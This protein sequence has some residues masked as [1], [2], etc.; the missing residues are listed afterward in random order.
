MSAH[1]PGP[2]RVIDAPHL[3][4]AIIVAADSTNV[5][6]LSW[7]GNASKSVEQRDAD[8]YVIAAAPALLSLARQYASECSE[9]GGSGLTTIHN[10][11][12][13]GS[14]ADDQPCPDCADIREVIALATGGEA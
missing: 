13:A 1:T 3:E 8:G 2:W 9:C 10:Y 11:D 5:A 7:K 6:I 4:H 14:D 12:G